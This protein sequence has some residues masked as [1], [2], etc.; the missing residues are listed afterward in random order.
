[1]TE[2]HPLFDQGINFLHNGGDIPTPSNADERFKTTAVLLREIYVGVCKNEDR[3][4]DNE[5]K[6]D[7]NRTWLTIIT[8]SGGL[9][10]LLII[11]RSLGIL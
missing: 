9:G 3:S 1:M 5:K 11:L 10:V 6:T 2:E 4:R 7:G 8:G